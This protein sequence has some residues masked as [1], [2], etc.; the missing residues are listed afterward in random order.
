VIRFSSPGAPQPDDLEATERSGS[1]G[2]RA[3]PLMVVLDLLKTIAIR[4][5]KERKMREKALI[6]ER[7]QQETILSV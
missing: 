1:S 7:A 6:E 5:K 4:K 2:L 3:N